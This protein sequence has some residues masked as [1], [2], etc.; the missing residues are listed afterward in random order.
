MASSQSLTGVLTPVKTPALKRIGQS[1][2]VT[3]LTENTSAHALSSHVLSRSVPFTA[4]HQFSQRGA[5][6]APSTPTPACQGL[7]ISSPAEQ[8]VLERHGGESR[9]HCEGD[10]TSR[11]EGSSGGVQSWHCW[12]YWVSWSSCKPEV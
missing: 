9:P 2:S 10:Q 8:P 4:L 7:V 12:C 5:T 1:I 3:L 11:G 6:F